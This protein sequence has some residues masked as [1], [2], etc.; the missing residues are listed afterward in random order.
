MLK[1]L[2]LQNF[3]IAKSCSISFG[4][5]FNVLSGETGTGK[6]MLM[7]ALALLLGQKADPKVIRI[8]EEKAWVQARFEDCDPQVYECLIEAGIEIEH[9]E[10]ILISRELN[11]SGKNR[12]FINSQPTALPLLRTLAPY[13]IEIIA[14]H[15]QLLL[16]DPSIQ[17]ELLDA[18]AS[19]TEKCKRHQKCFAAEEELKKHIRVQEEKIQNAYKHLPLWKEALE[20]IKIASIQENE[21]ETLFQEYK[22]LSHLQDILKLGGSV[23]AQLSEN[24]SSV[25][26]ALKK[27]QRELKQM[28]HFDKQLSSVEQSLESS[29]ELLSN[30]SFEISCYL[31]SLEQEPERFQEIEHRLAALKALYKKYG[32]SC[33]EIQEYQATLMSN[34]ANVAALETTLEQLKK[35]RAA[36]SVERQQQ[37]TDLSAQRIRYAQELSDHVTQHLH[38]LNMHHARFKIDRTE[39]AVTPFGCDEVSFH[40]AA[41]LG[42]GFYTIKDHASGGELSRI[43]FTLKLILAEKE[44]KQTLIFDEIDANIGGVTASLLGKKLHRLGL[45]RQVICITHFPQVAAHAHHHMQMN[46]VSLEGRMITEVKILST[47]D[48]Q[49]EL[50]RMMGGTPL[51]EQLLKEP[52]NL[53]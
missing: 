34:I 22:Q 44:K 2:S 38:E 12:I 8:G 29:Y 30:A 16:K 20:E 5:G 33:I 36:L 52:S 39:T 15:S 37:S 26:E 49:E 6:T 25:L 19:L 3:I 27:L 43:L 32:S 9:N 41:N 51:K 31:S 47:K 11:L 13:L 28:V 50:L 10:D 21:E 48:K 53:L 35:E 23:L 40:L 1:E 14:Q 24:P 42:E 46:K 45:S 4:A 18:Y 17:R 7:Q